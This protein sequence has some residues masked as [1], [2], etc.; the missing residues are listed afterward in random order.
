MK[1]SN[2]GHPL[3]GHLRYASCFLYSNFSSLPSG[4]TSNTYKQVLLGAKFTLWWC[5]DV[6]GGWSSSFFELLVFHYKLVEYCIITINANTKL[7]AGKS[8]MMSYYQTKSAF[9]KPNFV[10]PSITARKKKVGHNKKVCQTT[11]IELTQSAYLQPYELFSWRCLNE[12]VIQD[13]CYN[14]P[15]HIIDAASI[16]GHLVSS[17]SLAS[18][19]GYS[20]LLWP[21]CSVMKPQ[22]LNGWFKPK[23]LLVMRKLWPHNDTPIVLLHATQCW[24]NKLKYMFTWRGCLPDKNM[25]SRSLTLFVASQTRLKS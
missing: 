3:K 13:S 5:F 18:C 23:T 8:M 20:W 7:W 2:K 1:H 17:R 12:V 4:D 24:Q 25:S 16:W 15:V 22:V 19:K 6:D 11:Y 14:I 21:R 10:F 9:S